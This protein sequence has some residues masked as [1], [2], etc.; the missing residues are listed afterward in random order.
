MF[1]LPEWGIGFYDRKRGFVNF[2]SE[3]KDY[4]IDSSEASYQ[5]F[6][7]W[8]EGMIAIME[9]IDKKITE[10]GKR[11]EE[12]TRL[13]MDRVTKPLGLWNPYQASTNEQSSITQLVRKFGLFIAVDI[14][15]A[16]RSVVSKEQFF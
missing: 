7:L 1:K 3:I 16:P 11:I 12:H 9:I 8:A 15:R 2:V 13:P 14:L 4:G 6:E 5:N 10:T